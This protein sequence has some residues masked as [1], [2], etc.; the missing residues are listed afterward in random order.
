MAYKKDNFDL[1][2]IPGAEDARTQRR[3][4]FW[5]VPIILV[6]QVLGLVDPDVG[7]MSLVMRTVLWSLVA[8]VIL[9]ALLGWP[10]FL[11]R[12]SDKRAQLE[13]EI[14]QHNRSIAF[15]AGFAAC[16]LSGVATAFAVLW[17]ELAPQTILHII[18]S[19][20][21]IVAAFTFAWLEREDFED[22]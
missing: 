11:W 14:T 16:V 4:W 18:L 13:D 22:E 17:I 19:A 21:L 5:F 15:R 6:Q 20:G 12:D 9:F 7:G 2:H 1:N 8:L 3:W 10:S